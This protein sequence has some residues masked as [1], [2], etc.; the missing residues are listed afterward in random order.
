MGFRVECFSVAGS[1]GS[2]FRVQGFGFKKVWIPF[3]ESVI[4]RV[5]GEQNERDLATGTTQ[6]FWG[7]EHRIK[8]V[9]FGIQGRG[10]AVS[11]CG[12]GHGD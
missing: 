11:S 9:W 7:V 10:S 6:V 5:G 1:R 3:S 2:V 12:L 8:S 4:P